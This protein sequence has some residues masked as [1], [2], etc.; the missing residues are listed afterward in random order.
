MNRTYFT[1]ALC[2]L[3]GIGAISSREAAS[4][5]RQG[6]PQVCLYEHAGYGGWEQCFGAG[7]SIRD[8][9]NRRNQVSSVRIFGR[10]EI[11]LYEHPNFQGREI[12][13]GN[14]VP[15][16]SRSRGWNDQTDSL[17][18]DAGSFGG[19]PRPGERGNDRVCVYQ[20]ADYRGNSKCFDA[21]DDVGNLK[22][23]GWNDTIS[24]IRTF[25][26]TRVA[27]FE[28]SDYQGQRLIVDRDIPDLSRENMRGGNWNDR[29][30]SLRTADE[31]DRRRN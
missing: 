18:V 6:R 25:G 5:S 17:R 21:G 29:I 28:D 12:I 19:R 14:D 30:S 13:I 2:A 22:Q 16:L 8:L 3:L 10:A 9:G 24:S 1:F 31:R 4:Q 26:R 20:H 27:F 15:D 11:T 7:D 23:L